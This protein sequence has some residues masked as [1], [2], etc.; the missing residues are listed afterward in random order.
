MTLTICNDKS[1]ENGKRIFDAIRELLADYDA[2]NVEVIFQYSQVEIPGAFEAEAK[3]IYDAC[4]GKYIQYAGVYTGKLEYSGEHGY[5]FHKK[6]AKKSKNINA[7]DICV[8]V[9]EKQ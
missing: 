4:A 3:R 8:N 6:Y 1:A 9:S 2:Q 5:L 7:Y